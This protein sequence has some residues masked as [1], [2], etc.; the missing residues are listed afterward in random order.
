[1]GLCDPNADGLVLIEQIY[2]AISRDN[3]SNKAH[4]H[5]AGARKLEMV[6]FELTGGQVHDSKM[7]ISLLEAANLAFVYFNADMA[8]GNKKIREYI[9]FLEA[10]MAC[11]NKSNAKIIYKLK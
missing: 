11:S 4:Q 2:Y 7:A 8:Y 1:M 6:T 3:T 9:K 10:D 5:A